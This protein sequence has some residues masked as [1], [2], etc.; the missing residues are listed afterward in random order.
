MQ[1]F[2]VECF[3]CHKSGHY[4]NKCQ[5]LKK[6]LEE[7]MKGKKSS[8]SVSITEDKSDNVVDADLFSVSLCSN[9]LSES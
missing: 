5:E 6:R 2:D 8:E 7:K 3:D 9:F 4:K 1:R